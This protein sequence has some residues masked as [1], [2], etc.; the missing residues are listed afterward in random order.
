MAI[1]IKNINPPKAE[2]WISLRIDADGKV[3]N[4]DGENTTWVELPPHGRLIDA[5][6]LFLEAEQFE[7][8]D[9]WGDDLWIHVDDLKNAPTIIEAST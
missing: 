3:V 4:Y 7:M 5:D 9:S 2:D 6:R 1:L 8:Q